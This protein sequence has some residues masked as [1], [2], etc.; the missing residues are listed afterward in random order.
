[1]NLKNLI[2]VLLV[3][4][5]NIITVFAH[6]ASVDIALEF[7]EYFKIETVTS[8][9]LTANIT[10]DTG[11]LYA[12]LSSKF[13]VI[14]NCRETKEIYLKSESFTDGGAMPS[15]FARGGRV[16]IAFT[17]VNKKPT[18]QALIN[19]KNGSRAKESPGVVA[20]PITSIVGAK[21][22]YQYGKNNYKIFIE[23]GITDILVN[24]GSHVLPS[25]FDKNDPRGFYQATLT[26]TESEI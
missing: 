15:M 3:F 11:N 9:V 25:S 17:N 6:E 21:N 19:C 18:N 14:S 16:Y 10:D 5:F 2:L 22:Q 7:P 26:L 13:K 4:L 24:V 12:P 8:P 20:Y 23:N 1:M